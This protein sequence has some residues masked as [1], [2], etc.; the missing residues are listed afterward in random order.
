[1]KCEVCLRLMVS[2]TSSLPLLAEFTC[3]P[4]DPYAIK[5]TFDTGAEDRVSWVFSRGV[6]MARSPWQ[7]ILAWVVLWRRLPLL[8]RRAPGRGLDTGS[9]CHRTAG[10]PG[11]AGSD[12]RQE[13]AATGLRASAAGLS[14]ARSG[15]ARCGRAVQLAVGT[16][17]LKRAQFNRSLQKNHTRPVSGPSPSSL[18]LGLPSARLAQACPP[19]CPGGPRRRAAYRVGWR[20]GH[21]SGHRTR[22]RSRRAQT[23]TRIRHDAPRASP[24]AA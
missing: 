11:R 17:R 6:A 13:G 3:R 24:D 23:G 7:R 14:V 19:S 16:A 2:D 5:V 20:Q 9:Q 15:T 8:R 1:V 18:H 12:V 22:S 10:G 21:T 4:S